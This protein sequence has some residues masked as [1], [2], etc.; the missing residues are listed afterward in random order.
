MF[1]RNAL[2]TDKTFDLSH[3]KEIS[4]HNQKTKISPTIIMELV[5]D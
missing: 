4:C 5:H 1:N 3:R 2:I